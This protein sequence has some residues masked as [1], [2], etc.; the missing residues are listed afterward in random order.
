MNKFEEAILD[1]SSALKLNNKYYQAF[2]NRGYA[3]NKLKRYEN[4]IK[5]FTKAIGLNPDYSQ[6]FNSRGFSNEKLTNFNEAVT[7]YQNAIN[8]TP[9]NKKYITDL[10]RVRNLILSQSR[11]PS[12]NQNIKPLT[13]TKYSKNVDY[14]IA[15]PANYITLR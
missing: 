4:A 9:E 3:E 8:L 2:Y 1:Y 10:E 13:F 12:N 11:R 5:D 14:R 6:A 15:D 7:D